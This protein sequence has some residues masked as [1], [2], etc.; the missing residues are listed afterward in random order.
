MAKG[1]G[2][3]KVRQYS[4]EFKLKAVQLGG[5]PAVDILYLAAPCRT[6]PTPR[7]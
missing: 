6:L 4:L 7:R 2:P 1:F 3:A 5:Q